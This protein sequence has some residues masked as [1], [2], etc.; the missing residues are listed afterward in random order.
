LGSRF[1]IVC[2][3]AL[4]AALGLAA[5]ARAVSFGPAVSYAAG[6]NANSVVAV[7][8]SADGKL[9]LLTADQGAGTVSVLTGHGDGTFA[10]AV[11]YVAGASPADVAVGDFNGD[12]KLDAA[13]ADYSVTAASTVSVLLGTGGGAFAPPV[14]YTVDMGAYAIAAGDVDGDGKLDL[15]TANSVSASICVLLGRGDGTFADA[16]CRAV[17]KAPVDVALPDLNGDGKRDLVLA[18]YGYDH[19]G[20]L[21]GNGDGTFAAVPTHYQVGDGPWRLALTDMNGDGKR[22]VVSANQ[23]P[24]A[25]STISSESVL[26]GNGDGSLRPAVTSAV[27]RYATGVAAADFDADARTDLAVASYGDDPR[28]GG[29]AVLLGRGDGTV[30]AG[31]EY[32]LPDAGAA[33]VIAADFDRD[34]RPDVATANSNT[35]SVSVVLNTTPA[36]SPP[37]TPTPP[38][39]P[40][41]LAPPPVLPRTLLAC[42]VPKLKGRPLRA[43]KRMLARS[44]CRTGRV[45]R[46][47]SLRVARGRVVS[48]QYRAGRRLRNGARVA[49]AVSRGR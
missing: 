3:C 46:V 14:A 38:P 1:G 16:D 8:A 24:A 10:P 31:P 27:G 18:E 17:P 35:G 30:A 39:P 2:A 22:D 12:G 15:V 19:V 4:A 11:A 20:V 42:V 40:P 7:D 49:L 36:A 32:P 23:P 5:P 34:G 41:A 44:H 43:A 21:L 13:A 47:Y 33:D 48:Q 37:P 26:L 29:L 9:D 45:R 6:A 25:D 28:G